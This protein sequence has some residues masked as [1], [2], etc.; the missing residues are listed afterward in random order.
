MT[1]MSKPQADTYSARHTAWQRWEM[2]RF[3]VPAPEPVL[4]AV[5]HADA[6]EAEA[7]RLRIEADLE[8]R[9]RQ[10]EE[11]GQTEGYAAGHAEGLA[12]G[13]REGHAEGL[14]Q[15]REQGLQ[16]GFQTGFE[17]GKAQAAQHAQQ[18]QALAD[19][20]AEALDT[21]EHSVGHAL[22]QLA[23]SIAERVVHSTLSHHPEKMLDIVR[24][25]V[26]MHDGSDA[27]LTL[28]VHP[29]DHARVQ[30]YLNDDGT[31]KRWRVV[32]DAAI[33]TGGCQA[34]TALG[35]VDATLQTR[36]KKALGAVGIDAWTRPTLSPDAPK[37]I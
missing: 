37:N 4:Q 33:A 16:E 36:W 1:S 31:V 7:E 12:Q 23:A 26:R 20:C 22:V 24:D 15:G 18:L 14:R 5:A 9:Q 17:N 35:A 2:A 28:H 8:H 32:A 10:A 25:I 6:L 30:D 27:V 29:D 13:T 19:A 21:L 3:D 11:R 34:E